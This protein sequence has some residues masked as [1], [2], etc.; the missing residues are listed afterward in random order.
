MNSH[1]ISHYKIGDKIGE[2]GM[3]SIYKAED[4]TLKR[5]VALKFL[6]R[7][8]LEDEDQKAR[9]LREAQAAA[10]LDHPN[11]CTVY[12]VEEAAGETF[13]AMAYLDGR[14]LRDRIA[15]GPLDI[16]DALDMAQ[17]VAQGL[18]A[19]HKK[20]VVH[21]DIKPANVIVTTEGVAKIVDFGL[22]QLGG[23]GRLT[24]E[25][26]TIGTTAYMSPEQAMA[27]PLDHRTDIWSLGVLIHEM[28]TGQ[29]PFR[30]HYADAIVYSIV[31]E[32]PE[33]MGELRSDA[34]PALQT[35]RDE[36]P[37]EESR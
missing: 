15:A 27:A 6:S 35:D 3:G 30:G 33:A 37:S 11:I 31:N 13:I 22:A 21:R 36:G 12:E 9:F 16:D 29:T 32:E 8:A 7:R 10:G 14:N 34:P 25:G 23:E 24:K 4:L 19:A 5:T 17:Q 18:Q 2:G 20:E 1:T 28:V 26:V